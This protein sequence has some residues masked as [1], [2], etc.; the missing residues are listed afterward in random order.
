[1]IQARTTSTRRRRK[2]RK[3]GK[4]KGNVSRGLAAAAIGVKANAAGGIPKGRALAAAVEVGDAG[5][6]IIEE[7]EKLTIPLNE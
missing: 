6:G 1:M 2:A 5:I 7:C 3:E 4:E